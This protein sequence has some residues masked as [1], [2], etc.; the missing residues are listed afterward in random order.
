MS[1]TKTEWVPIGTDEAQTTHAARMAGIAVG[2]TVTVTR[3]V[4]ESHQKYVGQQARVKRID[5]DDSKMT[6]F[7]EPGGMWVHAVEKSG[8]V[9]VESVDRTPEEARI[10]L[11]EQ[12]LKQRVEALGEANRRLDAFRAEVREKAIAVAEA[13]G[14]CD[15]GLNEVLEDLGLEPK[16][17]QQVRFV[18]TLKVT[19]TGTA[20][21]GHDATDA[22]FI[23]QSLQNTDVSLRLDSDWADYEVEESEVDS[24][25]DV[26]E[27]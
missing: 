14:W 8:E 2:D 10:L 26:E 25:D 1:E 3:V 9:K 20:N 6:F 12:Q 4:Q 16:Q 18:V 7:V 22:Q 27:M 21:S 19:M 13:Q 11:L 24:I 15:D 17:G 5:A 23:E